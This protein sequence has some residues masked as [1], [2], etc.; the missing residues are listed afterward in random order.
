MTITV[1]SSP[2]AED[3]AAFLAG[4]AQLDGDHGFDPTWLPEFLFDFQRDLVTWSVRKGR[5]AILADC[6]MGKA[7]MALVWAENVRQHTDK[8]VLIL[9]PLAVSFQ[10]QAEADK[11]GVEAHISRDGSAV[12]GLVIANYERLHYFRR[13]DF[14]GVV[15]DEASA[16]KAFDGTTRAEVTAFMRHMPYRLL[17]TATAAPNDFIELGTLSEA[18]GE[19]GVQDMLSRF[20]INKDKTNETRSKWKGA[21]GDLSMGWR[22]K[23][24]AEDAFWQWVCSWA[25]ALRKPSDLGYPDGR[26]VLPPLVR[27]EHVV[28]A[29]RPPAGMLFDLPAVAIH[30]QRDEQR[31]SL[32]ERCSLVADLLSRADSAIAWCQLNDEGDLLTKTIPGA[33]QV[34]GSDDVEWKEETLLRFIHG[35]IRVLVTKPSIAAYGLNMQ[36]CHRMTYF[37]SHSY[38]QWYQAVRRCWRFGQEHP[39]EVDVVTTQGGD[40]IMASLERKAAQADRMFDNLVAHMRHAQAV[41]RRDL[42][43]VPMEVPPWLTAEVMPG[44]EAE[45]PLT[46]SEVR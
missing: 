41:T 38:E 44:A 27:R 28:T 26:F 7:A 19:L 16:L 36:H 42:A 34:K 24:H 31:R 37:P 10:L 5:A 17:C 39:V 18:L 45:R 4:K 8:P 3:Y 23:G 25:R 29:P 9:S 33:V 22:F 2:R 13:E 15:C 14:G 43:I 35:D 11:F 6:G 1:P 40:H 30:E 32:Q 21:G 12:G 46:S 20:F